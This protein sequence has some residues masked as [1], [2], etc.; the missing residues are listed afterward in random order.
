MWICSELQVSS[1]SIVCCKALCHKFSQ[2]QAHLGLR[3]HQVLLPHVHAQGVKQSVC[4][5]V[6]VV[7]RAKIASL[8]DLDTRDTCKVNEYVGISEKLA[9][10]YFELFCTGHKRHRYCILAMPVDHTYL[11]GHVL[12]ALVHNCPSV[13]G[14]GHQQT[15]CLYCCCMLHCTVL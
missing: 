7:I 4:M 10:V 13:T 5:S 14:N 11:L 15:L 6:V 1:S 3:S 8:G 2:G 9:S 12:F